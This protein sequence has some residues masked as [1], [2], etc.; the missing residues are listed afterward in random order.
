MADGRGLGVAAGLDAAIARP[1]AAQAERLGYSSIWSNDTPMA[2]GIETDAEFGRGSALE[3]G[4]AVLAL[5]R[6]TP[7]EI[8]AMHT[9]WFKAVT[10]TVA[11]WAQPYDPHRW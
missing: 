8:D 4:V 5:D 3:L 11:L 9:A 10:L 1:L 7:A 2:S 6:H